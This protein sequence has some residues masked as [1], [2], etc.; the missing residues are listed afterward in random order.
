MKHL[1]LWSIVLMWGLGSAE[2]TTGVG[3]PC[4]DSRLEVTPVQADGRAV[5]L[6]AHAAR[7]QKFITGALCPGWSATQ[8]YCVL[9]TGQGASL[10][11]ACSPR[12]KVQHAETRAVLGIE[13]HEATPDQ[14]NQHRE[15][16]MGR[17]HEW[18]RQGEKS[19]GRAQ[20]IESVLNRW[21]RLSA[22]VS[23]RDWR[24]LNPA[25]QWQPLGGA[26]FDTVLSQ[27]DRLSAPERAT[28]KLELFYERTQPLRVAAAIA[29][30]G[31]LFAILAL[32]HAWARVAVGTTMA[33][34]FVTEVGAITLRV[35]ISG[36]APITNM[37]ETVM[38][39]GFGMFIL[40]S[41]I[42]FVRRD[43][44]LWCAAF[45]GASVALLFL[46]FATSMLDGSIQPL[47]PVLRDNFWLSTHVTSVILAYACF[48]LSWIMANYTVVRWLLGARKVSYIDGWN[49][50]IRIAVQI[51]TV[52]LAA[53][54]LLGGIWADYSWGR[55]W[56]WDPKE[57]WSLIALI[58]YIAILHGRYVGWFTGIRFTLM[59]ALAFLFVLM[60]WFGVNYILA[61]GLHSYGFSSGGAL[62]LGVVFALQLSLLG[63]GL[64]RVLAQKGGRA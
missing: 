8:W 5:P 47:V 7:T 11:P 14:V 50:L 40:A 62:F 59:V 44:R 27:G 53:G 13:G 31:F 24:V 30:L 23:G 21:D 25:Q 46:N 34:L 37:Y 1:A 55:F 54:V 12:I 16:L 29:L 19:S 18:A 3:I 22:V 6:F 2:A 9:S 58:V 43:R 38:I 32:E 52:F 39:A 63:V 51:G 60:A 56:G 35:L 48:A 49:A 28:F 26:P 42:G 10:P 17:L 20:D 57:T 33:A 45:G 41:L 36:R 64:Q 4:S 15:E 61:V